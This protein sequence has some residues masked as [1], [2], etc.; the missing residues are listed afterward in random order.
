M[1]RAPT[2]ADV[3]NAVAEPRRRAI[4]DELAR[5]GPRDVSRLVRSLHLSQPTV[6]KH[7][8]V[9]RRV[10]LVSATAEGRRRLYRLNAAQLRPMHDWVSRFERFWTHQLDRIKQ[11]AEGRAAAHRAE[12][13]TRN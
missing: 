6:S 1:P 4:L 9:L 2:T 3:F 8:G 11:R 7:L 5:R 13:T 12:H 10:G